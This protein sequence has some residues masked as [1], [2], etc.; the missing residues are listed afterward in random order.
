MGMAAS[1]AQLLT[2][3]AKMHE[4]ER[5]AQ[6]IENRKIELATQRDDIYKKYCDALDAKKIQVAMPDFATGKTTYIDANFKNICNY[7][8]GRNVQYALR[9]AK[10]NKVIVNQD[11]Y[12]MYYGTDE[13][14]PYNNDK[15]AFAW[16]MMGFDG[17]FFFED[18]E[19]GEFKDGYMVG[20]YNEN[21]EFVSMTQ[22][23]EMV[24]EKNKD[25]NNNLAALYD[26][27]QTA[28][29]GDNQTEISKAL[30]E[31]RDELY[32]SC[33]DDLVRYM[34]LE[35]D[36][37][38]D[39]DEFDPDDYSDVEW[40]SQDFDLS[41][42]NYYV[43]LFEKI[44]AAGGCQTIDTLAEDGDTGNDW[45]NNMINS[46]SVLIDFYNVNNPQKGWTET[47]VATS[48]TENYLKEVH[49]DSKDKIAEAEYEHELS[50][51]NAKD[52]RFD[53][54]LSNLETERTALK[55]EMDAIKQVK[56]DNV[57]RTFGIFS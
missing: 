18:A 39:P 53:Q 13:D 24:F 50:I 22:V 27:L 35:K 15:Y 51:I 16:E 21:D 34:K 14:F 54:E 49:D 32:S 19:D 57:E 42:F 17:Q 31:F 3:T 8:P 9:D 48:T 23:E 33:K 37:G 2:I 1:Q 29:E 26:T 5:K 36:M 55:T 41:E 12:D 30:K 25:G 11:V 7:Q 28:I 45:L 47:S 52:K 44:Q 20:T 4:V 38:F 10:T 43:H 40:L 56:E 6:T 46:G